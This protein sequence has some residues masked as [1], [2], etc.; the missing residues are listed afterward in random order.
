MSPT[1]SSIVRDKRHKTTFDL[2][3]ALEGRYSPSRATVRDK[4][5]G[6]WGPSVNMHAREKASSN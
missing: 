1:Y 5:P 6:T 4:I 2:E 3:Q